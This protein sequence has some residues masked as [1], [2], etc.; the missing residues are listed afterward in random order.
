MANGTFK[1]RAR[2]RASKVLPQPVGPI[3][4]MFDLSSSISASGS[5]PW[6]KRL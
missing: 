2:V 3:K 6:T 4:R 1:T 5:S